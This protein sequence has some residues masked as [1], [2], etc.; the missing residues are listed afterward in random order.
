MA[1][2]GGRMRSAGAVSRD[3]PPTL[4]VPVRLLLGISIVL[5]GALIAGLTDIRDVV[6]VVIFVVS[7]VSFVVVC[8]HVVPSA[9]RAR[10]RIPSACSTSPCRCSTLDRPA[11]AAARHGAFQDLATV[12][13]EPH[14]SGNNGAEPGRARRSPRRRSRRTGAISDA[15][16]RELLQSVVDFTETSCAR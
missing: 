6:G 14:V 10:Q 4:F 11:G 8:E 9:H 15:E 5:A 12:R 1:E 16:G 13:R 3:D 2:R 7:L